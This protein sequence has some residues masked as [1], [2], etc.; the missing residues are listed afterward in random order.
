[1]ATDLPDPHKEHV[2]RNTG[3]NTRRIPQERG[4]QEIARH[5]DEVVGGCDRKVRGCEDQGEAES[6]RTDSDK[7]T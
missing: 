1:M 6:T 5:E 2:Q 3:T 4:G 7:G